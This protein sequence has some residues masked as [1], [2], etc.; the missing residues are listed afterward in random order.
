MAFKR[1]FE[2]GT[3]KETIKMPEMINEL[4]D[5]FPDT[6][7]AAEF[8]IPNRGTGQYRKPKFFAW[9]KTVYPNLKKGSSHGIKDNTVSG[10]K[11]KRS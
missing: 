1:L 2:P 3:Q 11:R 7:F 6:F 5:T 8:Y 4:M 10:I 9:M